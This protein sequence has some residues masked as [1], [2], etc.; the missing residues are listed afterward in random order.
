M[1]IDARTQAIALGAVSALGFIAALT[2]SMFPS[3]IPAGAAADIAKSAGLVAGLVGA[4]GTGMG[5][6][7]SS[8]PGPLAPADPPIVA[9]ATALAD[10]PQSEKHEAA[11]ALHAA[12]VVEAPAAYDKDGHLIASPKA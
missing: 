11:I 7:S 2:P 1:Q 4:V 10:A 3:F 9:A 5:L 6:F 12:A 8:R